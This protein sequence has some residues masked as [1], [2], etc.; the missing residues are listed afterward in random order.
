MLHAECSGSG[1]PAVI[2]DAALGASSLSWALVQPEVARITRTCAY[3]RAG[4]GK[5]PAGPMPRTA[6][7]IVD[8][9]REL[10]EQLRIEPPFVIVGH[11]FGGLTARLFASRY[12][13]DMAGLV[14]VDA[15][16]PGEWSD[17]SEENRKKLAMGVW[18]ARRGALAARLGIARAVAWMV[19][20]GAEGAAR[21]VSNSVSGG[22]LRVHADRLLAPLYKLPPEL[23]RVAPEPWLRAKFYEALASQMEAL[24]ESAA[25][26]AA[27]RD[28]GSMPLSVITAAN[29]SPM[30]LA[31]Q[32]EASRLS[33]CGRHIVA[34]QSGHWIPFD[35]PR[36]V[37][38]AIL[39]VVNGARA[40]A[41]P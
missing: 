40:A 29:P 9:L 20:S 34:A 8:E 7:R 10:L 6:S 38:N 27:V 12:R 24:P 37:I 13:A 41:L 19:R 31:Q 21:R 39:D 4:L 14:L 11:S 2:F 1:S 26:V 17:M 35:E 28:L 16:D 3:D 23:R 18:L 30:R 22:V 33:S 32:E 36:L 15:P 5:S 25:E